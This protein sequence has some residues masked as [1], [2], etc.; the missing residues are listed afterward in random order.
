[1]TAGQGGSLMW[2]PMHPPE[3][4]R[5]LAWHPQP[6]PVI[7]LLCLLA[8]LLYSVGAA[9]LRRL[10]HA[11]PVGRWLSFTVG[12]L[13]VVAVTATAVNGY[14][15]RLFSVHM[16]QHMVLSMLSP[17]LLLMGAPVTLC[18]RALPAQGAGAQVRRGV[19][20]CLHSRVLSVAARP[21]VTLPLFIG[22]LYGLYFTP[23]FDAAMR[24]WWGHDLMLGHF[25]A[26]GLLLFWPIMAIDPSPRATTPV[27]RMLELF[28]AMP[29]HAFFG[30]I[31]MTSTTLLVRTFATSPARWGTAPVTDQQLGGGIAW[32]FSEIPTLLVVAALFVQWSRASD[33]EA[34]RADR[35]ADRDDAVLTA[36]NAWL[37]QLARDHTARTP[38]GGTRP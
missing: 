34:R 25:L 3:L 27:L 30:V 7:P 35:A 12:L 31:V 9:R 18:L 37:A 28:V 6:L 17:L 23:V 15:M 24:T 20:R 13:T 22:S 4:G 33:R 11:W 21:V 38:G 36:Y 29:F 1:M 32:A 2:M 5:L 26:V 10:G 8:W 19:V 14:A 16:V